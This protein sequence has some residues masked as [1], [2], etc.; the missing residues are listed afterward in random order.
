IVAG[1]DKTKFGGDVDWLDVDNNGIIDSRDKVYVGNIFPKWTG[2]LSTTASYKR[3]SLYA[4]MDYTTGHTI[5]NYVRTNLNGQFVGATNNTTDILDSWLQQGDITNVPRFYWAD[6]VAQA[7]Y[8]RGDP[9]NINNGN[10]R[11]LDYQKGDYLA[12]REIT[13][14]YLAPE[15]WFNSIGLSAL[16]FNITANNLKYF[17]NYQGLAP[18][19]GGA[20]RGR[21]PVPRSIIFGLKVSF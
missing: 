21:Y 4:R 12:I 20:D 6:Q 8:W 2:G 16:K 13:L 19:D 7:N 18:E 17:T 1:S 5:Y 14:T 15:Q 3:L 11:D 9:R 10:G